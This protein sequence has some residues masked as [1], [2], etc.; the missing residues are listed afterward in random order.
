MITFGIA[1]ANRHTRLFVCVGSTEEALGDN[2]N[3]GVFFSEKEVNQ[4]VR[5]LAS[6]DMTIGEI[7]ARMGCTRS[8]IA[9]INRKFQVRNY[10][11]RRATWETG[12][13]RLYG[14]IVESVAN[15]GDIQ[16]N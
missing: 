5:L 12:T 2:M 15:R 11:G 6:T 7:A 16:Q 13:C 9:S 8:A 3:K 1:D 10:A 4:I 14:G